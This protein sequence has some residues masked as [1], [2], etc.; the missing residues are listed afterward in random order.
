MAL[1]DG[2][3]G[4]DDARR[5]A[6]R[7]GARV[8][9]LAFVLALFAASRVRADSTGVSGYAGNGTQTCANCHSGGHA[10]M[11]VS[12][13]GPTTIEAGQMATYQ[14]DVVSGATAQRFAGIDVA[15]SAGTLAVH[16]GGTPTQLLNGEI[17]HTQPVGPAVT[18][19][20]Q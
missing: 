3:R 10:P 20:F 18:V 6:S 8:R 15:A 4:Q 12:I 5:S 1:Q 16:A 14:I 13:S 11:R 7:D 19:S 2:H 17:T 9:R